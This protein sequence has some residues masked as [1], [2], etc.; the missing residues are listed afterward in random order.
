MPETDVLGIPY[1]SASDLATVP[2]HLQAMA[3]KTEEEL[4]KAGVAGKILKVSSSQSTSSTSFTLLG[5]PDRIQNVEVGESDLLCVSYIAWT[6]AATGGGR[7]QLNLDSIWLAE[8]EIPAVAGSHSI[9]TVPGVGFLTRP[10]SDGD[11]VGY[12]P[13]VLMY[14][15]EPG[16]YEVSVKFK[17]SPGQSVTVGSRVLAVW[18]RSFEDVSP[19]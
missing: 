14:H 9:L 19:S 3:E 1:P 12:A 11:F 10:T 8:A 4:V 15:V 6:T 5:T 18:T 16:T 2:D 17:A 7:V 13:G